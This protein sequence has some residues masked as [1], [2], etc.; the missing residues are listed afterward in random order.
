MDKACC[1][2]KKLRTCAGARLKT[3]MRPCAHAG[4]AP[5]RTRAAAKRAA[6]T[7]QQRAGRRWG[8]T[9]RA[10]RPPGGRLGPARPA[11]PQRVRRALRAADVER[12]ALLLA[13]LHPSKQ[14]HRASYC[15]FTLHNRANPN[16][17]QVDKWV[18]WGASAGSRRQGWASTLAD[19][20]CR[21]SVL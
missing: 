7:W 15:L 2:G 13:S 14:Q 4:G 10:A 19:T 9:A 18:H 6:P 12:R 5:H 11:L 21:V 8:R 16:S 20:M 17:G 3:G 1:P